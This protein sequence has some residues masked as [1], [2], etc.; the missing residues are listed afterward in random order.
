MVLQF[1]KNGNFNQYSNCS[2]TGSLV[3]GKVLRAD[4]GNNHVFVNQ[5]KFIKILFNVSKP[6]FEFEGNLKQFDD[7]EIDDFRTLKS[8]GVLTACSNMQMYYHEVDPSRG[9]RLICKI[10]IGIPIQERI[11]C[12]AIDAYDRYIAVA[13]ELNDELTNLVVFELDSDKMIEFVDEMNFY[14]DTQFKRQ[15]NYIRDMSLELED[16][17]RLVIVGF[18]FAGD[19][20]MLPFS[21]QNDKIMRFSPVKYC[22]GIFNKCCSVH[23]GVWTIDMNGV[24]KRLKIGNQ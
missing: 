2:P 3:H 13:T 18:Q 14:L 6:T 19:R 4:R 12:I 17:G 23:K 11:T 8:N 16:K 15:F 22:S 21:L 20:F 7:S 9:S 1:D 24:L 5:G 10:D